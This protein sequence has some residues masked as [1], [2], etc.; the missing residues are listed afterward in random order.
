MRWAS[1][2]SEAL[3]I[4]SHDTAT[5]T[6]NIHLMYIE[7]FQVVYSCGNT[8]KINEL[9]HSIWLVE[10]A[11]NPPSH[12]KVPRDAL[13]TS[14]CSTTHKNTRTHVKSE[15]LD[16]LDWWRTERWFDRCP[17]A[18]L[19]APAQKGFGQ[20]KSFIHSGSKYCYWHWLVR[21]WKLWI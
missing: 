15:N 16:S 7:S 2:T 20:S 11:Y 12:G 5:D 14:R 21:G 8:L 13:F 18:N 4:M 6:L 10:A 1:V 9:L 19:T 17:T 3:W